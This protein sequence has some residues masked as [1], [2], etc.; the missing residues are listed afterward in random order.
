M[1]FTYLFHLDYQFVISPSPHFNYKQ[2]FTP[3]SPVCCPSPQKCITKSY[4]YQLWH[5]YCHIGLPLQILLFRSPEFRAPYRKVARIYGLPFVLTRA[6]LLKGT[7]AHMF[8]SPWQTVLT[9]LHLFIE[10][11]FCPQHSKLALKL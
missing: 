8:T 11:L 9:L 2:T 7:Y 1:Q 3:P 6:T 5:I 10:F 4:F